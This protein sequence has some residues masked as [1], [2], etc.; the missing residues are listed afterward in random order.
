MKTS[1]KINYCFPPQKHFF[2]H[3]NFFFPVGVRMPMKKRKN[4]RMKWWGE[5]A[6]RNSLACRSLIISKISWG[7]SL[8][9]SVVFAYFFLLVWL[10]LGLA[11]I[12]DAPFIM[13]V[14]VGNI[15][16]FSLEFLSETLL[17]QYII[18]IFILFYLMQNI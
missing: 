12:I 1:K 6:S 3:W 17:S 4:F 14:R 13:R 5:D 18:F 8:F 10:K 15:F 16:I 7:D 9:L 2:V 11:L